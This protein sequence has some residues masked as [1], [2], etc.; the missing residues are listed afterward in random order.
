MPY[1]RRARK[2]N[3][4]LRRKRVNRRV[5]RSLMF[6]P[7]PVFTETFRMLSPGTGAPFS[8]SPNTGGVL[9]VNVDMMPQLAQYSTL[10]QKYRILKTQFICIPDWN[11][12]SFDQN[13]AIYNGGTFTTP[14]VSLARI[15]FAVNDSPNVPAPATEAAVLEDNGCKIVAGKSKVVMTCRP[16]P[17]T[18]DLNGNEMTFKQKYLNFKVAQPN[19]VHYGISWWHTQPV[20]PG[21]P[22]TIGTAYNVYI[23]LT[24]QLSDPR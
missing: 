11:T 10:Y 3:R 24:F 4:P 1:R 20:L 15:V 17:N 19:A 23:K 9:T 16:V 5:Q 2:S 7:Q 13:A 22:S 18:Q 21:G 12:D 14:S 6:N 8:L